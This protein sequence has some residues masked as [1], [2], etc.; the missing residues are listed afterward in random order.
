MCFISSCV[1]PS[2]SLLTDTERKDGDQS[3]DD[4][5]QSAKVGTNVDETVKIPLLEPE[6]SKII[7]PDSNEQLVA[8]EEGVQWE[9][10]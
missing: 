1:L 6:T 9:V 4:D 2:Y 3:K 5:N 7:F 10:S 8:V